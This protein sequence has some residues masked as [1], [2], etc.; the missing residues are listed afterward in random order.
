MT[1]TRDTV[2][3]AIDGE[4]DYQDQH[5]LHEPTDPGFTTGDYIT[6]M[7]HYVNQLPAAWAL[8]PGAAPPEVLHNMRK[9]AAIAVQC[10]EF[11]GALPRE[12]EGVGQWGQASAAARLEAR[13]EGREG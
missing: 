6:M 12:I 13:T 4:R 3:S 10:M 9:I 2:Y 11:H 8:N 7:Q 5:T 1:T